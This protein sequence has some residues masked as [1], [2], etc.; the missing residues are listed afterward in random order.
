MSKFTLLGVTDEVTVCD[1]C[2]KRN[3]KVTVALETEGGDILH[4][5]R[6]CAGAALYGRKSR[7]NGA[8]A[9]DQARM[10]QRC[11][12]ILPKVLEYIAAGESKESIYRKI[13]PRY[14]VDFG[15]YADTG[16]KMPLRIYW[17][18]WSIPGVK[19]PADQY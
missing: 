8:A 3:L 16:E 11:R 7:K 2:G 9:Y 19:V 4:Y 18:G 17:N 14:Y 13:D 12:D 6:D 1:C 15:Y 10:V 5:G